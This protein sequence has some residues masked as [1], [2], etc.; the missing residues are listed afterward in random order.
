M[1]PPGTGKTTLAHV[2][3]YDMEYELYELN[4]SDMR[5]KSSLNERLKPVL[6]QKSLF[7]SGKVILIDEVDGISGE[8]RGGRYRACFAYRGI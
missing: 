3:A 6:E 1:V 7:E 2:L 4:A 5:N 8:D